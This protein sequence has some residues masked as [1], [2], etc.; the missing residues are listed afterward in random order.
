MEVELRPLR[1]RALLAA[2][3]LAAAAGFAVMAISMSDRG[4]AAFPGLNGRI[5]FSSGDSYSYSSA[6]IWTANGDGGSPTLL[7]SG[8]GV[9]TP[10]YSPNGTRIAFDREKGVAVM[11]SFGGGVTQLLTGTSDQS[12][13]TEWKQ[14]YHDPR[15]GKTIP[16]VRIQTSVRE[17]QTYDHPAFSP[18]GSRLVVAEASGRQVNKSICAVASPGSYSCLWY[19]DLDAY[20]NYEESCDVC[21]THLVSIDAGSGARIEALT[22]LVGERRDTKPTYAAD[23][24][25]AF[26]R[27]EQSGASI[28]VIDTPGAAPRRVTTGQSDRAPDFSPDSSKIAFSHGYEDLG[29][30]GVS[31]GAVQLLPLPPLTDSWGGY[32]NSPAFSPDGSRVVFRRGVYGSA[33]RDQTGL[34]AMALDGSGVTRIAADGYAPSWQPVQPPPPTVRAKVR[35]RKGKIRLNRRG[36]ALIGKVVCGGTPCK[37]KARSAKLRMTL[38][39]RTPR[40]RTLR[41]GHRFCRKVRIRLARRLGVGR[42]SR[43]GVKVYGKCFA[44]LKRAGKGTL[45]LRVQVRDGLGRQ[46]LPAKATLLRPKA[47][48]HRRRHRR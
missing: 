47:Q 43:L 10:S 8:P 22:A 23:G 27:S 40:A 20:F 31:G 4:G 7:T 29:L 19:P 33:G 1:R 5:A 28:Y 42:A 17:W 34:F 18:D 48:K 41:K 6:A 9:S 15:E 16:V 46:V 26:S 35:V 24:K 25:I 11:D 14:N 32:V 2:V 44:A 39:K 38:R 45:I 13:Q 3:V 36:R 37:L 21:G 12:F 30:V